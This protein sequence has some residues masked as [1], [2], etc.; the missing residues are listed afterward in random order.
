VLINRGREINLE[1]DL[2]HL[3]APAT[4]FHVY[5][6]SPDEDRADLGEVAVDGDHV[7]LTVAPRSITTLAAP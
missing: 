6:T 3:A 5:R 2:E 4:R 7:Q 1:V